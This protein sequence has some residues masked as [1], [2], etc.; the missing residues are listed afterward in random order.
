M[1]TEDARDATK[2]RERGNDLY[3]KGKLGEAVKAYEKA[4]SLAPSD[5]SPLS[6]LS[7][8]NFEAGK[9]SECV[10]FA[11]KA[12]S[13]LKD[14]A[15][16]A[17]ARQRLLIRQAKAYLHLSRLEEAV[18]LFDQLNPTKEKEDL[19]NLCNG[20]K[21]FATFSAQLASSREAILQLP[22]LRPSIQDEPDYF[23]PGH[24]EAKS[25]YTPELEKS[26]G[27]DPVLSIM[28][29]GC[30]DARHFFQTLLRYSSRKKGAQKLCATLLDH[31]PA[32]IARDLIFFSLLEKA[33]IDEESKEI[34]L[35]SLSYLYCTQIIPPFVWEQLQETIND[36]VRKLEKKQQPLTSAWLLMSQMGMVVQQLK[37]WQKGPAT[38]YKTSLIRRVVTESLPDRVAYPD[39]EADLQAFDDFSVMFPPSAVL[40]RF[41]PALSALII[42][43]QHGNKRTRKRISDYLDKHWKVNPTLIDVKWQARQ[44]PGDVPTMEVD[45]S[46]IVKALT[47][48]SSKLDTPN[49]KSMYCVLK[50]A[51]LFFEKVGLAMLSLKDRLMIE[52]IIG[53]MTEVL[54]RLRHGKMVRPQ[55][56]T[57]SEGRKP[58]DWP[59]KYHI[60]HMSNIPDYIGGPL[61]SFLYAP[62]LLREGFGTGLMSCVLRN[63]RA[64]LSLDHINAEY[65]LMYD[66]AM[67]QNHFSVRLANDAI[68]N[69]S[70]PMRMGMPYS[71]MIGNYQ[72][73]ER[74]RN[75]LSSLEGLMPRATLSKW[76]FAH[77]LKLC[78]PFPRAL[79]EDPTDEND[80][81]LVFAPFNMTLFIRLLV[82][83]AELGY[84]GHWLSNVIISICGGEITT[85]AR[86]PRQ[87]VLDPVAVD[88]VY[89]CRTVN[90]K[91]WTAEFTTLVAQWRALLPFAVVVRSG[92]LPS[93]ENIAEYSVNF[94]MY[95]TR[96]PLNVPHFMLV[97]W[98]HLKYGEPPKELYRLLLD[99]EKG[100]TTT[101]ARKIRADGIKILSTFKWLSDEG[102]VTFWLRSDVVDLMVREDWYIYIWRT[103]SWLRYSVGLPLKN[104]LSQKKTWEEC[105]TSV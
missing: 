86:A 3:R 12:L 14:D 78:L 23:G 39:C 2:I 75:E 74:C 103:D 66:R 53:D 56:E 38:E 63:P 64:W 58:S 15:N 97:F 43:Y 72:R 92:I 81:G 42:G 45:P 22:R 73:W 70:L 69:A 28:L 41:E 101:S 102:T 90:V 21:E 76:L 19:S 49:R 61:M 84:P 94:P 59:Q 80:L 33:T 57:D 27:D 29:C 85:T 91:P 20:S 35:L 82:Q 62:P 36:L 77:F 51:G 99:D 55:Q 46:G 89:T 9:Y 47:G 48:N 88:K 31:K 52:M 34:T 18:K 96:D 67:I 68:F 5:P 50:H 93:P 71:C 32:V 54:E 11:T 10:D 65:L 25:L 6:N 4:A 60:I 79:D 95:P 98:N 83:M 87:H 8:A 105:V 7:A 13:L 17:V 26:A 24:D 100:D 16:A 44:Q 40:S 104:H 1:D 30:G 37:T